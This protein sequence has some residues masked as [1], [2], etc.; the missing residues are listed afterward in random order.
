M[1]ALII[2]EDFIKFSV[3]FIFLTA[4]LPP[5]SNPSQNAYPQSD[6]SICNEFIGFCR[7]HLLSELNLYNNKIRAL[8]ILGTGCFVRV[9]SN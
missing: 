8:P 6:M 3:A 1:Y 9:I 7:N 5:D 2:Y 4:L